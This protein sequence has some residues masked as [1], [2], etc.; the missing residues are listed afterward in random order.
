MKVSI[1]IPV[2]GVEQYI[3]ECARSL[4][5]QTYRDLEFNFV[6]DCSPDNSISVLKKVLEDY[7]DRA[8]QV[9]II[10][11]ESNKG[12]GATR[13]TAFTHATG[14]AIL[15]VDSD[16]VVPKNAVSLLVDE[17]QKAR[18]DIVSG[19]YAEYKEHRL[20]AV[21][22]HQKPHIISIFV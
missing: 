4:F 8:N 3:A 12:L 6:D 2:Y 19:A 10:R 17:M 21:V 14:D 18:Y 9:H 22:F 5:S 13:H 1:L 16:D 11:H 7:P 20:G 15:H